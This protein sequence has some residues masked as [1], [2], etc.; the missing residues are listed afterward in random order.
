MT[1][2]PPQPVH[3]TS[4][5]RP[6]GKKAMPLWPWLL[7]LLVILAGVLIAMKSCRH[8]D[9]TRATAPATAPT[10]PVGIKKVTLPG[11]GSLDLEPASLNYL[12]Q[13]YL[14]SST[15]APRTFT[16]ERLN[17][18]TASA[19]LPADAQNTVEA[20]AQILKAYPNAKI[21]LEGYAD[22]RGSDAANAQLGAQ[23]ATAVATALT[24][25]GISADRIATGTGGE[26]NPVDTNATPEGRAENRRT[27]LVVT[28]K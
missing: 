18:A 26:N 28:A 23:R 16:F 22:A 7:L 17:F 5:V 19:E 25:R 9:T 11:G 15:P 3:G 2:T 24:S 8:D 14:A 13:E 12:L 1:T 27:E 6:V 4:T 10:P 21:R 20:L